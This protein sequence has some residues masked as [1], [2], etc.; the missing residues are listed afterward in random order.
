MGTLYHVEYWRR[1]KERLRFLPIRRIK[2]LRKPA[3]AGTSEL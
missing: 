2:P 3:M 1:P